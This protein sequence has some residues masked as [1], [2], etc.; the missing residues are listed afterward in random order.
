[1]SYPHVKLFNLCC[2]KYCYDVGKNQIYKINNEDYKE[3]Q[4]LCKYG[5]EAYFNTYDNAKIKNWIKNGFLNDKRP[6]VIRH[7]YTYVIKDFLTTQTNNLLL[8]VTQTC[9]LRCAYCPYSGSGNLDRKHSA[10]IMSIQTAIKAVDFLLK[11]SK[12]T[13]ALYIGFYGGEPL[14]EEDLIKSVVEY[15]KKE[16]NGKP[17]YYSVTTNATLMSEELVKFFVKNNF[18]IVIS[19]DG[20]EHIHNKN[21]KFAYNGAGSYKTVYRTL[22]YIL[23]NYPEFVENVGINAVWDLEEDYDVVS[24]FFASDNVLKHYKYSIIP[25][26]NTITDTQFSMFYKNYYEKDMDRFLVLMDQLIDDINETNEDSDNR[27]ETFDAIKNALIPRVEMPTETHHAGVCFPGINRLFVDVEGKFWPCE[28]ISEISKI[29]T[30]GNVEDGY[31]YGK[32]ETLLNLG[33]LTEDEC[34]ACWC[35]SF[36]TC[37]LSCCDALSNLSKEKKLYECEKIKKNTL[38]NLTEFIIYQEVKRS[39]KGAGNHECSTYDISLSK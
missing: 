25:V 14:L 16:A 11:N 10:K 18:S 28:K 37:C 21:R 38:Y 20:P 15:S 22:T 26:D 13:D 39:M 36:C 24:N 32:I 6:S 31:H 1:M 8:Q 2:G 35:S 4:Y 17:I 27:V 5:Y 23:T 19:L 30:I 29:S 3:I 33:K 34:K 7:P 12:Y 9:N